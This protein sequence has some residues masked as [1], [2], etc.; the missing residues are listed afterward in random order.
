[1][2]DLAKDLL[3]SEGGPNRWSSRQL[4]DALNMLGTAR[5]RAREHDELVDAARSVGL[6]LPKD[7]AGRQPRM[8]KFSE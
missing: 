8:G 3:N 2:T 6:G 4:A 7:L 1:M 5:G